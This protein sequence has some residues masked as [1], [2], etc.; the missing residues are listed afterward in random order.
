MSWQIYAGFHSSSHYSSNAEK[1][2]TQIWLCAQKKCGRLQLV[3]SII[4]F[5][6]FP[7]IALLNHKKSVNNFVSHFSEFSVLVP[8][9]RPKLSEKSHIPPYWCVKIPVS[10]HEIAG[11]IFGRENGEFV[12]LCFVLMW[13]FYKEG[14]RNK[15]R[16]SHG[17]QSPTNVPSIASRDKRRKVLSCHQNWCL[18]KALQQE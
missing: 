8:R 16:S 4:F 17:V 12:L 1:N 13:C 7:K 9:I 5:F 3:W 6:P 18:P 2:K 10:S 11:G 15:V 14:C